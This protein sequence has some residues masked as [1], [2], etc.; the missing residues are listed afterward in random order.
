MAAPNNAPKRMNTIPFSKKMARPSDEYVSVLEPIEELTEPCLYRIKIKVSLISRFLAKLTTKQ[1]LKNICDSLHELSMT[2]NA[3]DCIHF[4]TH[5]IK[6]YTMNHLTSRIHNLQ[7][8]NDYFIDMDTLFANANSIDIGALF[9]IDQFEGN[10]RAFRRDYHHP[11]E[12]TRNCVSRF[13]AQRIDQLSRCPT[14]S[15]LY[16]AYLT[17]QLVYHDILGP[18]FMF[19][20]TLVRSDEFRNYEFQ[21][22]FGSHCVSFSQ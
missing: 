15:P 19:L 18:D 17:A 2:G 7:N 13:I 3:K 9:V 12:I 1:R 20:R 11:V 16:L 21:T 8:E 14:P 6:R 22:L 5:A 4:D 10:R